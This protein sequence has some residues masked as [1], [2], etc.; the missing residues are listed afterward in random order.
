MRT[1]LTVQELIDY[2]ESYIPFDERKS[3]VLYVDGSLLGADI[4]LQVESPRSWRKWPRNKKLTFSPPLY[5]YDE[6]TGQTYRQNTPE[7][8]GK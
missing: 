2:I 3:T 7:I 4:N 8:K 6:E 5:Y 1:I